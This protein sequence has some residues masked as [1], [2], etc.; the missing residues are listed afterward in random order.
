MNSA[1]RKNSVWSALLISGVLATVQPQ[2][3]ERIGHIE[4]YGYKGLDTHNL[5]KTLPVREGDQYSKSTRKLV[6]GDG[7]GARA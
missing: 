2:T 1:S 6:R 3:S 5:R 4:F 7:K